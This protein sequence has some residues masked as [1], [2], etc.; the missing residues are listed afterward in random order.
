MLANRRP[1]YTLIELIVVM[2]IIAILAAVL[3]PTLTTVEGDRPIKAAGDLIRA[4]MA[5]ARSRAME[6]G[7]TYRLA[8]SPDGTRVR[9]APDKSF[10]ELAPT[11]D[12]SGPL[13]SDNVLPEGVTA[14]VVNDDAAEA[15]VDQ[16]GWT[17][18]ATFEPLGTCREAVVDVELNQEGTYSLVVRMRGLTGDVKVFKRTQSGETKR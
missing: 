1:G 6:D 10:A 12:T 15:T 8:L 5:E 16:Y 7:I 13:V 3:I 4:R 11:D 14:R 17:R 9:I 18:V 2:A